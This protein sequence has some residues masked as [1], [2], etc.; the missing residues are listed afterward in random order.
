MRR[1]LGHE[2]FAD[3][4]AAVAAR[5][6]TPGGGAV[7]GATGAL[8]AA[9]GEMVVNY[10]LGKKGLESHRAALEGA[11]KRLSRA[12][13]LFLE[14]A[15]EDAQAYGLINELQKL[16][17]EH[18]R[19]EAEYREAVRAGV[20]VPMAVLAAAADV[21]AL[22][23]EL[24]DKTNRHLR[25]DLHIAALLSDAAARS[26]LCNVEI[27]LGSADDAAF[28]TR[29]RAQASEMLGRCG[30]HLDAVVRASVA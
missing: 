9:L 25:S 13:G 4:L 6:P 21:L 28:A 27:N 1:T 26:A 20:Q 5:T 22:L 24:K 11:Q 16:P 17:P 3:L 18:P 30:V 8:G 14:L 12:R 19:R 2:R 15:D 23:D 29:T 7:A 10:S